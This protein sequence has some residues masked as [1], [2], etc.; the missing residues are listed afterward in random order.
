M[1]APTS[2]TRSATRWLHHYEGLHSDEIHNAGVRVSR[3]PF[4]LV[5]REPIVMKH[6]FASMIPGV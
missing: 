3:S 4:G 6:A 2:A 5:L 1:A